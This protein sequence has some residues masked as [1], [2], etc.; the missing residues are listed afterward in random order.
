MDLNQ[1]LAPLLAD[2]ITKALLYLASA[3]GFAVVFPKLLELA[4]GRV[5]FIDQNR[6]VI[7]RVVS[8]TATLVASLGIGYS[9][10]LGTGKLVID[11][12]TPIN[13]AWFVLLFAG[14]FGLQ[15]WVYQR[16][17]KGRR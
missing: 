14:Q 13:L 12:L 11:G 5:P 6:E 15:E 1:I 8:V 7:L 9:Y 10:D 4:K 3:G 17:L 2:G 16:F